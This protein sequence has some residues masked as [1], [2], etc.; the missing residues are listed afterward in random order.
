MVLQAEKPEVQ[1]G[2]YKTGFRHKARQML[3]AS[4]TP[5]AFFVPGGFLIGFKAS[6][7]RSIGVKLPSASGL[8]TKC[9]FK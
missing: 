5:R 3:R 2:T 6:Q 7:S 8:K 4:H 9:F 1:K